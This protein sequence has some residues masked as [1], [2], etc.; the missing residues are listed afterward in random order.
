[1]CGSGEVHFEDKCH[2]TVYIFV[3]NH[4]TKFSDF[5]LNDPCINRAFRLLVVKL[6][7]QFCT[8][9][10]P[11]SSHREQQLCR[12]QSVR[13]PGHPMTAAL[14]MVAIDEML[15]TCSSNCYAAVYLLRK[16]MICL[17]LICL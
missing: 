5:H 16:Y 12:I 14:I 11:L 6:A 8:R 1:M 3:I 10:F 17:Q 13:P 15:R 4:F 9:V 7:I 2:R